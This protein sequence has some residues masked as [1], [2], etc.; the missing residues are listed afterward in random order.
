MKQ[1][2]SKV[3]AHSTSSSSMLH[4]T[5]SYHYIT[6]IVW[7]L[8]KKTK[9]ITMDTPFSMFLL[10]NPRAPWGRSRF[11][12]RHAASAPLPAHHKGFQ[13][14]RSV[15]TWSQSWNGSV[16]LH[17]LSGESVCSEMTSCESSLESLSKELILNHA[18]HHNVS[19]QNILW[20]DVTTIDDRTLMT[21]F[22]LLRSRTR[23][24]PSFYMLMLEL[25]KP[26]RV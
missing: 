8:P 4:T 25:G 22:A 3:G 17:L 7:K 2:V 13:G 6:K 20:L 26:A 5:F 24:C 19:S 16:F 12:S 14:K 10:E 23:S 18:K 9:L 21:P 1:R 15:A 11:P